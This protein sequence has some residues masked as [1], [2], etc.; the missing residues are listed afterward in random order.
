MTEPNPY[1]DYKDADA[2]TR[3]LIRKLLWRRNLN[4][5]WQN[6]MQLVSLLSGL[7][8]SG[9]AIYASY[10]LIKMGNWPASIG[11]S[12]LAGSYAVALARTFVGAN[13]LN[14]LTA[15]RSSKKP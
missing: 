14:V 8:V 13:Q 1:A 7:A 10:D 4:D 15:G 3:K 5:W 6:F 12:A 11:G 2:E 9:G